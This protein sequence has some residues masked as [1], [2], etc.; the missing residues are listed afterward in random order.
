M[1]EV[2][3]GVFA[4][5]YKKNPLRFLIVKN[6]RT[7]KYS[8]VSGMKEEKETLDNTLKR[9]VKEEVGLDI[10]TIRKTGVYHQFPYEGTNDI[11]MEKVY[12]IEVK[13]DAE[14][15]KGDVLDAL[16]VSE[17][18]LKMYFEVDRPG[19]LATFKKVRNLI[20]TEINTGLYQLNRF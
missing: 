9:E 14:I 8:F 12:L 3:E 6:A 7:Q 15:Q 5:I 4:V 20:Q 13:P 1:P 18:Q 17:D 19:I 16:W 2:R 10:S 11:G